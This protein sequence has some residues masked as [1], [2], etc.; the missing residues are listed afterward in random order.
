MGFKLGPNGVPIFVPEKSAPTPPPLPSDFGQ[1]SGGAD[2]D[3]WGQPDWGSG[4]AGPVSPLKQYS[5][6]WQNPPPGWM[7]PSVDATYGD[8]LEDMFD[9]EDRSVGTNRAFT[10]EEQIAIDAYAAKQWDQ[11]SNWEKFKSQMGDAWDA[12]GGRAVTG[13]ADAGESL[14]VEGDLAGAFGDLAGAGWDITGD[15]GRYLNEQGVD[16]IEDF[17]SNAWNNWGLEDAW[18]S[19]YGAAEDFIGDIP[20][21]AGQFAGYLGDQAMDLGGAV[22]RQAM[23][24]GDQLGGYVADF[25]TDTALPWLEETASDVGQ[26]T[27]D[28][29]I[30]YFQNDFIEDVTNIAGGVKDWAT[31]TAWQDYMQPFYE[32]TL[33][34]LGLDIADWAVEDVYEDIMLPLYNEYLE[35]LGIDIADWAS[36]EAWPY[37]RDHLGDDIS[38]ALEKVPAFLRNVAPDGSRLD[39]ALESVV[40][41]FGSAMDF[42]QET[43]SKGID[44]LLDPDRPAWN[45]EQAA[46]DEL[47]ATIQAALGTGMGPTGAGMQASPAGTPSGAMSYAPAPGGFGGGALPGAAEVFNPTTV[48]EFMQGAPN[49]TIED[50]Y[51]Q[52]YDD[53]RTSADRQYAISQQAA[54]AQR[55]AAA[56]MYAMQAADA[57]QQKADSINSLNAIE[58]GMLTR[59]NE[60]QTIQETGISDVSAEATRLNQQLSSLREAKTQTMYQ[61]MEDQMSAQQGRTTA[62]ADT[63]QARLG[64]EEAQLASDLASMEADRIGQEAGMAG[65]VASRFAGARQGMQDR[66]TSAEEALR[67]QG[68]DPAAYTTGPGAE[69]MALL[70]SQELSMMTLQNRLRDANNAQAI[71]RQMRG[72]QI[73]SDAR[74]QLE[75]NMFAYMEDLQARRDSAAVGK[76]TEQADNDITKAATQ[77]EINIDELAGLQAV[78]E[79][80]SGEKTDLWKETEFAK[81]GSKQDY[82]AALAQ[83]RAIQADNMAAA[84]AQEFDDMSN[85]EFSLAEIDRMEA[86]GKISALQA[87]QA[88]SAQL[89]QDYIMVDIGDGVEIPV[90]RDWYTENH[91]LPPA[92]DLS[93][94]VNLMQMQ[95]SAG[96]IFNVDVGAVDKFGNPYLTAGAA[97][98]PALHG[99][100][101]TPLFGEAVEEIAAT[102]AALG[103]PTP[104][105]NLAFAE[106][107]TG[108]S[109]QDQ[110][111][112]SRLFASQANQ[113]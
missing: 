86:E 15:V 91:L 37:M 43:P 92:S 101:L 21:Y 28:T 44:W 47:Q 22:G 66:I 2:V 17:A 108:M 87:E 10:P 71:D 45:Q 33:K 14:F 41:G 76:F 25:A 78:R 84:Q 95:D 102:Q 64:S 19:A 89:A 51:A 83:A 77:G 35:P 11:M 93:S 67:A 74:R 24:W 79:S 18:D 105:Q 58:Q 104:A 110:I 27:Q 109:L 72:R 94:D 42:I 9:F 63:R 98:N 111:N 55:A 30:P 88:K 36:G 57:A 61:M 75:D 16:L 52:M 70:D 40:G 46:A 112:L 39:T 26:W 96:N 23:D 59:L 103:G 48:Q 3:P 34:P 1:G 12:T 82:N 29:A 107:T 65:Q 5:A 85:Y 106:A 38:D 56:D 31:D 7:S 68:I 97:T 20:G 73:Y 60:L 80:I 53:M 6:M 54:Q 8:P 49:L 90:N 69:T 50:R 113:G 81:L 62:F 99:G 100:A 4:Q 13:I 32:D